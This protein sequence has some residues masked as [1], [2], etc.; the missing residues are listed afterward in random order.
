M[1]EGDLQVG[2]GILDLVQVEPQ[3]L[4]MAMEEDT[5]ESETAKMATVWQHFKAL[6][7]NYM[8]LKDNLHLIW[9]QASVG[10]PQERKTQQSLSPPDPPSTTTMGPSP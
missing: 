10:G 4:I 9:C 6:E 7:D 1:T 3:Y 8:K 5:S 2:V